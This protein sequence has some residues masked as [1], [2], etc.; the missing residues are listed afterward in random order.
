MFAKDLVPSFL[1]CLYTIKVMFLSVKKVIKI[2]KYFI[3]FS[4]N[5]EMLNKLWK[6]F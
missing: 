2:H 3:A 4:T 6:I 1:C 5:I